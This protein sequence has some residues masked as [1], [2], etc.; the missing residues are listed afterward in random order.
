[1]IRKLLLA[2]LMFSIGASA[3]G[4]QAQKQLS[5]SVTAQTQSL[6]VPLTV[7]EE[8]YPGAFT[9]GVNRTQEPVSVGIPLAQGSGIKDVSQLG[10]S[11]ATIGQFRSLSKWPTGELKWVLVDTQAD[12]TAG[13]TNSSIKLTHGNGNFGGPNLALDNGTNITINTGIAQFTIKKQGWNGID[14]VVVHGKMIVTPG[15]SKGL[16]LMGPDVTIPIPAAPTTTVVGS[17]PGGTFPARTFYV[18]VGYAG[19]SG[20]SLDSPEKSFALA[21]SNLLVVQ[22]PAQVANAIGYDVFVG[23]GSKGETKVNR[24]PIPFGQAWTE[25][26]TC[27]GS[28][29]ANSNIPNFGVMWLPW[30]GHSDGCGLCNVVFS[31]GNDLNVLVGIEEN[32]PARAVVESQGYFVDAGG[33]R[34]FGHTTRMTFFA[35]K[36][37][38]LVEV[39]LRNADQSNGGDF[40]ADYKGF[41]SV[42]WHTANNVSSATY[43]F[44]TDTTTL[45]GSYTGTEDAGLLQGHSNNMARL[46]FEGANNCGI[47]GSSRCAKSPVYR[48]PAGNSF[49]Y[50][51]DG[52]QISH[53]GSLLKSGTASQYVPGWADFQDANGAGIEVGVVDLSANWPKSVE[54]RNGGKDVVIGINPDQTRWNDPTQADNYYLGYPQY[55]NG[56]VLFL[57][58][59]DSA[60][61]DKTGEFFQQ[62]Y[63]L[64]ARAPIA[65]YNQAGVF[66]YPLIDPTV[67][68]NY[69]KT[70]FTGA[71]CLADRVPQVIKFYAF[72]QPGAGNQHEWMYS[73]LRNWLERGMAG[74]YKWAM[75]MYRFMS[76][77]SFSR[78][79]GFLWRD[80]PASQLN[81][82]GIASCASGNQSC[83]GGL[84]MGN[85]NFGMQDYVEQEHS[86]WFGMPIAYQMT[87]KEWIRDSIYQGPLNR[88]SN[89]NI[90]IITNKS[91]DSTRAHGQTYQSVASLLEFFQ[92]QGDQVNA[93]AVLSY[94]EDI[95]VPQMFPDLQESGYGNGLPECVGSACSIGVSR[96]RGNHYGCCSSADGTDDTLNG[97]HY[98]FSRAETTFQYAILVEGL[99]EL[100]QAAGPS[101]QYY[102]PAMDRM[103]SNA[104]WAINEAFVYNSDKT[105][106]MFAY[107]LYF[108]YPNIGTVYYT[109]APQGIT[110]THWLDWFAIAAYGK[111]PTVYL[112]QWN[113][114]LCNTLCNSPNEIENGSHI[115][116]GALS[117]FL[118]P[119][120]KKSVD[121]PLT[122]VKQTDGS[123]TLSWTVPAG[124]LYYHMKS[125]ATGRG[126][127]DWMNFTSGI[128]PSKTGC[129]VGMFAASDG[130]GCWGF[131]PTKYRPFFG[132]DDMTAPQ[133]GAV[134]TVQSCNTALDCKIPNFVSTNNYS[135]A[136]RGMVQQ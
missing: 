101:W 107:W 66:R 135:F 51:E 6:S 40:A 11:G 29:Y 14:Q 30:A 26:S 69:L 133:P 81:P 60:I 28:C 90:R 84:V 24:Y 34:Y 1:M 105:Q 124:I 82:W 47:A 38:V 67:E 36:R 89:P 127:V 10:L 71:C 96:M 68:D 106:G 118:N 8:L 88:Y 27:V 131:D 52:Y 80:H 121:I 115:M 103:Y 63:P 44:G 50:A 7:Q 123:F 73:M 35:G 93:Q 54:G 119:P 21:A 83:D 39:W 22:P 55:G 78:S 117:V 46:E 136:L 95:L 112:D 92:S 25:P 87:G 110:T 132:A 37:Y 100:A 41:A 70:N 114:F 75:E 20:P 16:V 53:A 77:N 129:P 61:V 79:D 125:E 12:V 91:V 4:N 94:A 64:L 13:G 65:Q 102:W 9:T 72:P 5:L 120:T 126:F 59:H 3:S 33:H 19:T 130:S 15:T 42:E 31:A 86:H 116:E 113:K 85:V 122:A 128:D 32:G 76:Q 56:D 98:S 62:N 99:Y 18:R 17:T 109:K 104:M 97:Y 58:F 45:T 2:V 134:G 57:D 49:T 48:T 43:S 74:R 108:N 111:D 23:V